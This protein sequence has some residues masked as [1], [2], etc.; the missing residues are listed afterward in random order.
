MIPISGIASEDCRLE[1]GTS[2][3]G[4]IG[5]AEVLPSCSELAEA[6]RNTQ[7]SQAKKTSQNPEAQQ[8]IIAPDAERNPRIGFGQGG[9]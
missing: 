5:S 8:I 7:T 6:K 2:R 9:R 4:Y 1:D 3:E